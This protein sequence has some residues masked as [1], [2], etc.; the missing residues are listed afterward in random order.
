MTHPNYEILLHIGQ[1]VWF[2]QPT[3]HTYTIDTGCITKFI[4]NN[5]EVLTASNKYV[6][7]QNNIYV[8]QNAAM[9]ALS[10]KLTVDAAVQYLHSAQSMTDLIQFAF[11]YPD[12]LSK[13]NQYNLRNEFLNKACDIGFDLT[14]SI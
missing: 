1:Q 12:T 13:S 10:D 3:D 14:N 2:F 11:D 8:N 9:N 7:L 6:R 4:N 5:V